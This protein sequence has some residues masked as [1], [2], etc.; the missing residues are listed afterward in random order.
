MLGEDSGF[1]LN[2]SQGC[3]LTMEILRGFDTGFTLMREIL[4]HLGLLLCFGARL[5]LGV[6]ARLSGQGSL[7]G[8]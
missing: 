6:G 4:P 8:G 2:P 5:E 1:D 7:W 3:I